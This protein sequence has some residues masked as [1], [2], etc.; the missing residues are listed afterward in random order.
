[1]LVVVASLAFGVRATSPD[2][3]WHAL[4]S[5][6]AGNPADVVVRN[7]RVPRTVIGLLAG[8]GLGLAGTVA[9]GITRNP[10]ADPGLLGINA[11]ASFAV[12]LLLW[13]QGQVGEVDQVLAA[14]CGAAAAAAV[15]FSIGRGG[16]VHLALAGAALTA[17]L[18]PLIALIL[19]R[20]QSAFDN[21]RFWSVGSL[22]GRELHTAASLWPF[23]MLGALMAAALA[24]RLNAL[25]LG[26]DI[27]TALGQ[28]VWVT[29]ALAGVATVLLAGTAT[30]LAG[31]VAL[32]GLAVPHLARRVVGSDLRWVLPVATLLGAAMLLIADVVGRLVA[33]PGEVEAGI[34]AAFIG[35]PALVLIAR[36]RRMA[37]L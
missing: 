1:M 20:D 37:G 25:A 16:P 29:R 23:L 32:V 15:V 22:T 4:F 19:L 21:F 18:I 10:I 13:L 14:F 8:A 27:A 30:S 28:R 9:Q 24:S 11:G 31:P 26:E 7:L 33:Q 12:V 34:I 17:L 6:A 3:V 36:S 35:A 5:P 2:E